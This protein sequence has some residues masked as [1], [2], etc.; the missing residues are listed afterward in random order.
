MA[1]LRCANFDVSNCQAYRMFME[2]SS[3]N[4]NFIYNNQCYSSVIV[5]ISPIFL[6][7]TVIRIVATSY[8]AI[9]STMDVST[10]RRVLSIGVPSII[11]P[12]HF[13]SLA[14]NDI[15]AF[16]NC[17]I[18]S[19]ITF[20][21]V[22]PPVAVAC[23][24]NLAMQVHFYQVTCTG[25]CLYLDLCTVASYIYCII[26]IKNYR[27]NEIFNNNNVTVVNST[28]VHRKSSLHRSSRRYRHFVVHKRRRKRR[29]D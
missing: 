28:G 7:V 23:A 15:I 14:T 8:Y 12:E 25:Q 24:F 11:W 26:I 21:V 29:C 13:H 16:A 4:P 27:N 1:V 5:S 20:G 22:A 6:I 9:L 10:S 17:S 2:I 3:F 18:L 19:I